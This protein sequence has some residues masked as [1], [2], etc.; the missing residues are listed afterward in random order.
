[1]R[2]R[3]RR[4]G[5]HG[6]RL[7]ALRTVQPHPRGQEA[8][9]PGGPRPGDPARARA[10]AA[11]RPDR[12]VHE[13]G[14]GGG[15]KRLDG[16][17]DRRDATISR[18]LRLPPEPARPR[19]REAGQ[20]REMERPPLYFSGEARVATDLSGRLVDMT[21]LPDELETA[22]ARSQPVSWDA[23]FRFAELDR[24]EFEETEPKWA[25]FVPFD[26]RRAWTGRVGT[27]DVRVEGAAWRGRIVRF[28]VVHPWTRSPRMD[29]DS[30]PTSLRLSDLVQ[31]GA[32]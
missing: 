24:G 30:V 6:L 27:T 21:V 2:A 25:P 13:V 17:S 18:R 1:A 26:E 20:R 14:C 9:C 11:A 3:A 32:V 5:D 4:D 19:P 28:A 15:G 16:R 22:P 31:V 8:R 23:A 29:V 10:H 12:V 7:G